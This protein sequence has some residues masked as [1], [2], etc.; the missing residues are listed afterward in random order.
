MRTTGISIKY[1][2]AAL[3]WIL[4]TFVPA[5]AQTQKTISGKIVSAED[6]SII[7]YAD[8]YLKGTTYRCIADKN[9]HFHIEAPPGTY[10]LVV[11]AIGY[12]TFEEEVTL[13]GTNPERTIVMKP[14]RHRLDEVVVVS[15]RESRV[16]RS[17]FNAV[18]VNVKELHNSSKSLGEV[19]SQLPGL[20]LRESGG[21][22]SDAQLTLDGFSGKHVKVFIDGVPQEGAGTALDINNLPVNFAER[23]EVYKG[24]VPVEFGT[25]ALGG[26]INIVTK[27]R[28]QG[29][30]LDASYSYGS[31]NTH[32]SYVNFSQKFR[33]GLTYRINAFQ[34]YSDNNYWIDNYITEFGEDG[35]TENTDRNKI[36]HVRRFND[37]FHNEAVIGE[38]GVSGK[39]W[40]DR[41]MFGFN[42]SN[43]YKE[44]Q[45]GVYQYIVFGQKHRR[46]HSFVPSIEYSKRDLFTKGLDVKVNANYNHNI[47]MNIDTSSFKYNWLGDRK[48]TGSRGEQ[49][50]QDNR[51]R[52]TNWNVIITANYRIGKAHTLTLS[53]VSSTF[54][55]TTRSK[56]DGSSALSDFSIPKITRKNVTGLSYRLAPSRKWNITAFGKYYNQYNRGPV[57]Q[58]ND[59]VG[60]YVEMSRTT[61]AFG[62]GAA[63]ALYIIKGLQIKLSYEK[64]YRLPTTD[65]L[66]GDEDLEA[67]KTDLKPENSDN[68]NLNLGFN[69]HFGKHLV[70]L[71]GSLIYRDT[72]DYIQR[73]LSTVS[74]MSYGFYENHGRVRTQGFNVSARYSYS[75][76]ISVGGTFSNINV[77]DNERYVAGNT[78]QESAT[79]GQRMPNQPYMFASFDATFTWHGLFAEG[80][81][82]SVSYDGYYQHEFPLY[83]ERFGDPASKSTVPDQLSHNISISYSLLDGRYNISVE[84]RNLTDEKLYDNF[85]LQKAGRA[86]YAK[87]RVFFGN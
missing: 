24:V 60:N 76:W 47:T 11:A 49:S 58:S 65:E 86:F 70:S 83:W 19:L 30:N 44:I 46:G 61:N 7:D 18:D 4:V 48:Y 63:G 82:L 42:Y 51:S 41:L 75:R 28:R 64:A 80:N 27:K 87:L 21:V 78:L 36:Y 14:E 40:A 81:A 57:S 71:D 85:S 5:L 69:R 15:N 43:F 66:F 72:K 23:I 3:L 50:Y 73:G 56:V 2:I 35:V 62:Y 8:I 29:W 34:N 26:V 39:P 67:G 22:G 25:D 10:T 68:L 74:G 32:K 77:R 33:N 45:T 52:N 20:K 31:F 59:G 12:E 17:A 38:I 84:C 1:C 55:R 37:M 54:K 13:D 79:Y 6:R 9:G 16:Q 53:Q